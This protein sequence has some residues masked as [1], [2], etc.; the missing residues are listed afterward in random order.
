MNVELLEIRDFLVGLPAFG[1]LPS[2]TL[3][4]L[5]DALS[6]VYL[7]RGSTLAPPAG[8]APPTLDI[9][10]SGAL[11]IRGG[12]GERTVA[13]PLARR[14]EGD[15][16]AEHVHAHRRGTP[17]PDI[18][19][20]EDT[21][22][23]RLP[24]ATLERLADAHPTLATLLVRPGGERL[25]DAGA[26]RRVERRAHGHGGSLDLLTTTLGDIVER[27]PVTLP[28]TATIRETAERMNRE[29]VTSMLLVDAER[30]VGIVTDRDLRRHAIVDGVDTTRAVADIMTADPVTAARDT[31]AHDALLEM[32]R[33]RI[34][35]LP[36]TDGER[37]VGLV[38]ASDF[39]ERRA[40]SAARL[41]TAL[42]R[43]DD[44]DAL[45]RE[46]ARVPMLYAGLV[47]SGIDAARIGRVASGV[48][49]AL[50]RRLL[51]LADAASGDTRADG[52][53]WL[54]TG[55][56]ARHEWHIGSIRAN[57]A[58]LPD[59]LTGD[60]AGVAGLA[61]HV[62]EGLS[63]CGLPVPPATA[64]DG[65]GVPGTRLTASGWRALAL[66]RLDGLPE[67][68]G[69]VPALP[70]AALFDLRAVHGDEAAVERLRSD[71][72]AAAR[73]S[74]DRLARLAAA[75][76]ARRPPRGFFRDTVLDA[77]GSGAA[78]LDLSADG[79]RP[80][81][82]LARAFAVAAGEDPLTTPERLV[83][84]A[85]GGEL[86]A[87]LARDLD[88]AFAVVT[89]LRA[90]HHARRIARARQPDGQLPDGHVADERIAPSELERSDRDRL[91]DVFAIVREAQR[92]L[93]RRHGR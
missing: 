42:Y 76:L 6:I 88:D 16:V 31:L 69:G 28:P 2:D 17:P 58:L 27:A 12:D 46:S 92:V 24:L 79:V 1:A 78:A 86:D 59:E 25:R 30:L 60:D 57:A 13:A 65:T 93:A 3:G 26:R 56:Q 82:D 43:A 45:A 10:R 37:L 62:H 73:A 14:G 23:Y 34:H 90:R 64:A 41:A 55:S 54:V 5:T 39:V 74:P 15:A 75:A 84:A 50:T 36:V 61:R 7:R 68:A 71:L 67:P 38:T 51:E 81:V 35:H 33:H 11:E 8:D 20:L 9:V 66:E 21:L 83:A 48:A 19:A 44:V 29:Y 72:V 32:A 22:L 18:E 70:F 89:G 80:V 52:I 91:E 63:R 53:S 85:D 77:D 47:A 87:S 49:D 40:R 4:T